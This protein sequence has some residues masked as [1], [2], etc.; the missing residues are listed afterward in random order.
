VKSLQI[1][2][3]FGELSEKLQRSQPFLIK[4]MHGYVRLD[5]QSKLLNITSQRPLPSIFNHKLKLLIEVDRVA[6]T[7]FCLS[8]KMSGSEELSSD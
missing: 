3:D 1:V 7:A 6:K 4:V 5:G 2:T 8:L